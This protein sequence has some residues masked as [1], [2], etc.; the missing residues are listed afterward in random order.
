MWFKF[1][2][3]ILEHTPFGRFGQADELLV[4]SNNSPLQVIGQVPIFAFFYS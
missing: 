4:V 3:K 1:G 2:K